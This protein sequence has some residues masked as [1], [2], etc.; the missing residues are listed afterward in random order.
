MSCESQ[1]WLSLHCLSRIF[2]MLVRLRSLVPLHRALHLEVPKVYLDC[3]PLLH[4]KAQKSVSLAVVHQKIAPSVLFLIHLRTQ[5]AAIQ[6]LA[7]FFDWMLP[8]P[9]AKHHSKRLHS[10]SLSLSLSLYLSIS[11]A[12]FLACPPLS[13]PLSLSLSIYLL[14]LHCLPPCCSIASSVPSCLV[15]AIHVTASFRFYLFLLFSFSFS[16]SL[17]LYISPC[18]YI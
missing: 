3:A 16:L 15:L 14:P 6:S 13:S 4:V 5:I 12:C 17:S 2:L 9:F 1:I 8:R 11:L 7:I 18:M 10:F